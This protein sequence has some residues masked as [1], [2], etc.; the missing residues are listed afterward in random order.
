[1]KGNEFGCAKFHK[2]VM[3]HFQEFVVKLK[4]V[5]TDSYLN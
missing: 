3:E 1:M 2:A 4:A 5:V